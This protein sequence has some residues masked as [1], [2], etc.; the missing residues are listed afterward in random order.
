MNVIKTSLYLTLTSCLCIVIYCNVVILVF[1]LL[2]LLT[3]HSKS[4]TFTFGVILGKP[5]TTS[6][7]S[8]S[9]KFHANVEEIEELHFSDEETP[10]CEERSNQFSTLQPATSSSK[11]T[12]WIKAS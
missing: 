7:P 4:T 5:V 2:V 9:I 3:L 8:I 10:N 11:F 1:A 6:V 12:F